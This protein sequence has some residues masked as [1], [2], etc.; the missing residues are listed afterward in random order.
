M[1]RVT[2]KQKLFGHMFVS[3]YSA[4]N[5]DILRYNTGG[6]PDDNPSKKEKTVEVERAN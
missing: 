1:G 2:V 3:E 4:C 5:K 6:R